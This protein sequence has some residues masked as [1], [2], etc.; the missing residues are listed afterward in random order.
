MS[1]LLQMLFIRYNFPA[2]FI[3]VTGQICDS[4]NLSHVTE[5]KQWSVSM[6]HF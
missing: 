4:I 1:V 2:S 6:M 3:W 5:A